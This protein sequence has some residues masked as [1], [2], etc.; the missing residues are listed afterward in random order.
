MKDKNIRVDKNF[1][2]DI[3]RIKI[4]KIKNGTWKIPKPL[5]TRRI[6]KAMTRLNTW[7]EDMRRIIN[8]EFEDEFE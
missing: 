2:N 1:K 4:E 6:T 5:S 8:A 7:E 3:D